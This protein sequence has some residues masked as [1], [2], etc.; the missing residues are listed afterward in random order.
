MASSIGGHAIGL[1][2][3]SWIPWPGVANGVRIASI[4]IRDVNG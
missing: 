2:I 1:V 4:P 3:G